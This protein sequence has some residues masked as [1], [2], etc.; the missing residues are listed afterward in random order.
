MVGVLRAGDKGQN[1]RDGEADGRGGLKAFLED[2]DLVLQA[3]DGPVHGD[4][5]WGRKDREEWMYEDVVC[6][7]SIIECQ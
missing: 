1:G 4:V 6:V 7:K 2:V 3:R 5:I